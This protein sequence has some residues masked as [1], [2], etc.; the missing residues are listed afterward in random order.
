[1]EEFEAARNE[2]LGRLYDQIKDRFV[3]LYRQL[4]GSHEDNFSASLR[5]EEAGLLLEVD[6]YGRGT[7]PPHALHSEGHQDSMG[8][9]LYLALAERITHGVID[10]VMLD[11]VVMSVD[12]EHRRQVCHLLAT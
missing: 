4:N 8:L 1:M 12:A 10:V 2:V 6:F 7:H 11:D 3:G 5:P 9:C